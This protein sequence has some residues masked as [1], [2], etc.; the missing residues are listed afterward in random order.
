MIASIALIGT[1]A[2]CMGGT[3]DN[4]QVRTF[5][6]GQEVARV[7]VMTYNVENLFDTE[8]DKDRE[9]FTFLPLAM[10]QANP[11]LMAGCEKMGND[12]YIQECKEM[13]WNE[14][15]FDTKLNAVANVIQQFNGVGP[16]IQIL[17]EVEN[18]NVVDI[19]NKKKLQASKYI[20]S[21]VLEGPDTRGIDTG[22]L[23]R[24]PQ[25]DKPQM[26][27]IPFKTKTPQ[28]AAIAAKTRGILE[29]RLLLPGNQK[30]SI[31]SVHFPS[32]SNPSYLR[33]QA[34]EHLNTLKNA[35]P[36]DVIAIAGG[37][38]NVTSQEDKST[39]YYTKILG[40]EWLVS[41]QIGCR[42]CEGS[43]YY[44]K[45][46]TWSWFDLLTFSP[47]LDGS[48]AWKIDRNS[49]HTPNSAPGQKNRYNE[50]MRFDYKTGQGVSDHWPMYAEIYLTK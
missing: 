13:D 20:T 25:W 9:D 1:S 36:R 32:Q 49:I 34:I 50:P 5:A 8:H 41:H 2:A 6:G 45:D 30:A 40:S 24:F 42:G 44:G 43:Y 37:D 12:H 48:S 11:E 22:V 23:S 15:L 28:D 26:H 7:S 16:D 10:K 39:G 4:N 46:R 18:Q 3:I 31:F 35:L 47:S 33:Q 27:V 19:L 21:V 17:V 14:Q 29:V 38:F